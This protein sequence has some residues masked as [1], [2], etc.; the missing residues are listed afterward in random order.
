MAPRHESASTRARG[1]RPMVLETETK[2]AHVLEGRQTA[3]VDMSLFGSPIDHE[4]Y[5]SDFRQRKVIAGQD[6]DFSS[7][8]GSGLEALFSDMGWLPFVTL[9]EPVYPTLV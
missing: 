8:E 2:P 5:C 9:H 7:L 1:K 6:I 3:R 4:R